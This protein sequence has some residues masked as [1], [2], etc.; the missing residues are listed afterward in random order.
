[1]ELWV[2]KHKPKTLKDVLSQGSAIAAVSEWLAEWKPGKTT[3]KAL[4][5]SGPPG[6]GKTLIAE[7]A[8][9]ERGWML[10]QVNASDERNA[11]AVERTLSEVSKSSPLFFRGKIILIDEADGLGS[12]DRGGINAIVKIVKESRFPVIITAGDPYIQK[13]QPLRSVSKIVK[14]SK[15]DV[16]S[17]EK[18]LREICE[19]EGVAAEGDVLKN[20]ARWSSGDLRAAMNDL[21]MM[22]EGRKKIAEDDFASLGFRERE[23][24]IFS[25]LPTVFRSK[26]IS[27]AR[28]AIQN[29]DKDPDDVFWWIENNIPYEFEGD[30]LAN[31]YDILS[32][33]DLFRQKVAAQQN[34]RFR[35]HMIDMLACMSLAGEA[36]EEYVAYKPPDKFILLSRLKFRKAEMA[37]VYKKLS[38]YTHTSEKVVRNAYLPYLKLVLRHVVPA[39][40]GKPGRPGTVELTAEEV[41]TIASG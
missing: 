11:D 25:V 34:W 3:G 20:L 15:V 39:G 36:S 17:I 13:L 19:K 12:G 21:Q 40:N 30:S 29:C 26:N 32:K 10:A 1:M 6:I 33:A 23:A 24:T 41:G 16:R 38:A 2:D 27:A 14:L 18:R 35:M 22:C 7:T 8:A 9:K 5:L 28:N 31:A 37:S 4:L